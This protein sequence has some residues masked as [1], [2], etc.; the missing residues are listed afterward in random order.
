MRYLPIHI[1]LQNKT[2][3]IV[4]GGPAAEA[5]LR[6]L[7]KTDARLVIM[8]DTPSA[9]ILRW[10]DEG[11][12]EITDEAAFETATLIYAATESPADNLN[13][14][15]KARALGLPVN[16]ADQPAG[17]DF[18]TPA[19]VDRSPVTVSIG[20]EGTSPGLARAL[21]SDI[22][23]R[24]PSDLGQTAQTI[25]GL[26]D[27]LKLEE[28][29]IAKRQAFWAQVLGSGLGDYANL[30]SEV[31]NARY[32]AARH[33]AITSDD[34]AG[35]VHIVGAG[36]GDPDLLTVGAL[37]VMHSA[38]VVI[39][40]RLVSEEVLSLCRREADYIYVGKI[41]GGVSTRQEE[42]NRIMVETA[43]NGATVVRLKSGD[44]LVFG[45]AEEEFAALDA[46]GID[47]TIHPGITAATAAAASL[48]HSLTVRGENTAATL[49]TG[50]DENGFAEL[51]WTALA[52]PNA[53]ATIYMGLRAARFIQ[54]RLLLHGANSATPVSVVENAS[55]AN[56]TILSTTIGALSDDL[57]SSGIKGP[58]VVMIGYDVRSV[59][60]KMKAAS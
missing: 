15:E 27:T 44:P 29:D 23:S 59:R 33:T 7:I 34:R 51:D 26:R 40:D 39:Y 56:E 4:G 19:L 21:K 25:K 49:A 38:D 31:I 57:I 48:R 10:A 30:D 55:R 3:I 50:H 37:R 17:C 46:A 28:P 24:L 41:P 35:Y 20:T 45:R 2:V 5:K 1:D 18:I 58:A 12:V 42:I 22:E 47:F 13:I 60:A 43:Q 14:A 16:A 11:R 32:N 6:T 8:S 52:K 54:G 53:R 9:E 36:P